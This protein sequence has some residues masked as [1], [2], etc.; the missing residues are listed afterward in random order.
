MAKNTGGFVNGLR[1]TTR[2]PRDKSKVSPIKDTMA[3]TMPDAPVRKAKTDGSTVN[4][5]R[6]SKARPGSKVFGQY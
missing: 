5:V 4:Q 1:V 6:T 3:R 2:V